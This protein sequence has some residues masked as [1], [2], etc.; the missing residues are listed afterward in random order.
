[1]AGETYVSEL[2]GV[3]SNG[4]VS[5]YAASTQAHLSAPATAVPGEE[6]NFLVTLVNSPVPHTGLFPPPLN[7]T[8]TLSP[9]PTY[10]QGLEG[11][12]GTFHWY[13]LNC[14]A[15]VPIPPGGSETFAM[16]IQVPS[17]AQPGPTTLAWSIDGSPQTYQTGRSY[18]EIA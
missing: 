4:A 12:P 17:A 2:Y 18:L 7:P 5:G 6:V 10:H 8:M 16:S 1:M 9:C 14:A 15:A 3:P 11:I 13:R